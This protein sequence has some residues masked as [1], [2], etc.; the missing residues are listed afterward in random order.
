M[1]R[2]LIVEDNSHFRE[3]FKTVFCNKFPAWTLE[4][5]AN[6]EEAWQRVR[7]IPPNLIFVDIL[8]PGEDGLQLVQKIKGDLPD[9]RIAMLTNLD[10]PEKRRMAAKFGVERFFIKD[11]LNWEEIKEWVSFLS[12][13]REKKL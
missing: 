6:G 10:V 3:I 5:A 2:A 1:L 8:L 7:K 9:I 4:E 12:D 13:R 11:S